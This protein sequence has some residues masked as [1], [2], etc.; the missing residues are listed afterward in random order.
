MSPV[1]PRGTGRPAP[2]RRGRLRVA[3]PE[4]IGMNL[5]PCASIRLHPYFDALRLRGLIDYRVLYLEEVEA[6]APT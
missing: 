1:E 5:S 6:F 2:A 3:C 4:R